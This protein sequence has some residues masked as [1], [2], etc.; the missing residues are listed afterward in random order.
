MNPT[1]TMTA[2]PVNLEDLVRLHTQFIAATVAQDFDE[3]TRLGGIL[4]RHIG[5]LLTLARQARALQAPRPEPGADWVLVPREPTSRVHSRY[6][7]GHS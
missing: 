4:D 7:Q 2:P 1:Q 3:Q 6:R 5:T